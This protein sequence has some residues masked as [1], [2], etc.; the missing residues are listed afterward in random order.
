[1]TFSSSI[2]LTTETVVPGNK[3]PHPEPPSCTT[4]EWSAK[5]RDQH[6]QNQG[7]RLVNAGFPSSTSSP[8][9]HLHRSGSC[10][11]MSLKA[12]RLQGAARS[13][14]ARLTRGLPRSLL[15]Q[16]AGAAWKRLGNRTALQGA[17]VGNL[18]QLAL[19]KSCQTVEFYTLMGWIDR[20]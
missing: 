2:S 12:W 8:K 4:A 9:K 15:P 5:F 3:S 20:M 11:F 1:M 6:R 14:P 7:P 13:A 10:S 18:T 16:A 17:R 19:T